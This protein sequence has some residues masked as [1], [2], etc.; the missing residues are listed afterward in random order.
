MFMKPAIALTIKIFHYSLY[1][2]LDTRARTWKE[3]ERDTNFKYPR[4]ETFE[5]R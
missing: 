1:Q 4:N 3:S 2:G 5:A